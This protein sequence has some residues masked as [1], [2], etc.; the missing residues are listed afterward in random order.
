MSSITTIHVEAP[1]T[2]A[3]PSPRLINYLSRLRKTRLTVDASCGNV[4]LFS[5]NNGRELRM[6]TEFFDAL[7][8]VVEGDAEVMVNGKALTVKSN[9]IL[10]LPAG[11]PHAVKAIT[12]FKMLL[13][14]MRS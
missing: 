14:I 10:L 5:F 13:T 9:D 2:G 6:H 4:T 12:D 1:A 11:Q 8:Q 7:L 3:L